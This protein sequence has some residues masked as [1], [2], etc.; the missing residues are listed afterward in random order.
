MQCC[1]SKQFP[2]SSLIKKHCIGISYLGK[3]VAIAL[4]FDLRTHA[5]DIHIPIGMEASGVMKVSSVSMVQWRPADYIGRCE[6]RRGFPL[7]PGDQRAGSRV[8]AAP[9]VTC[10]PGLT[11][12][13]SCRRSALT[14][15]RSGSMTTILP[16]QSSV[17][18]LHTAAGAGWGQAAS[19]RSSSSLW[20]GLSSASL[21]SS[22]CSCCSRI[23]RV[24]MS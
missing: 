19:W 14:T 13:K 4:Q 7:V 22:S 5:L 11:N 12:L 18:S 10:Q 2:F 17:S 15:G 20:A 21:A 8:P 24:S 16:R 3:I 23:S 6:R 9:R 1:E